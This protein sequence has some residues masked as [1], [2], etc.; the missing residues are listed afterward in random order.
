M[1]VVFSAPQKLSRL[2]RLTEPCSS[3][4]LI[5]DVNHRVKFVQCQKGVVYNIPLSCGK[6]YIGQTGRCL[7]EH[8]REH[9]NNVRNGNNGH[10]ATHCQKCSCTPKFEQCTV[11]SRNRNQ[12]ARLVVE[13]KYILERAE[14]C[15]S[16]ASLTLSKK[17]IAFL[18]AQ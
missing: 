9:S 11:I 10:L 12:S 3:A 8:L 18:S 17:E 5:C 14:S 4:P 15:V 16:I 2:C 1:E 7:N 6:V 13:A